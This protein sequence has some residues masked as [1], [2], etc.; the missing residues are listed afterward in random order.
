MMIIVDNESPFKI[1]C[2]CSE[3]FKLQ[4]SYVDNI[5]QQQALCSWGRRS[6]TA[7]LET[8]KSNDVRSRDIGGFR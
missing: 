3:I 7:I 6:A 4:I 2:Y 8:C 5:V 1:G